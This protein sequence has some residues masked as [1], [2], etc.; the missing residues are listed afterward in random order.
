[1]GHRESYRT[2]SRFDCAGDCASDGEAPG[3]GCG[4]ARRTLAAHRTRG[5][6]AVEAIRSEKATELGV[7]SIAPVIARRT[8]KHLAAAAEKRAERWRRIG[9]EAAQ[10]SRRSDLRKLP[11]SESLRLRR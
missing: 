6:T 3:R 10:Q 7:A 8:E 4:E 9:H 5:G 1:M 11:N 2:R